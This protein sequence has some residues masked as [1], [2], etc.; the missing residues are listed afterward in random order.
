MAEAHTARRPARGRPARGLPAANLAIRE[1]AAAFDRARVRRREARRGVEAIDA[2][3]QAVEE[4][5]LDRL[6]RNVLLLPQ[7]RARLEEEGGLSIPPHID[8][9]RHTVR[10]HE[11][12]MDWQDELLDRA[13]LGRAD[14]ARAD[15]EWDVH[16]RVLSL[17]RPPP[18]RGVP[19]GRPDLAWRGAA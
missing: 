4:Y 10:L 13:V 3:L 2:V 17:D 11:A 1:A 15:Q 12:L 6:P 19:P 9:I 8:Q 5:H 18:R 16:Q 7:W 14:L